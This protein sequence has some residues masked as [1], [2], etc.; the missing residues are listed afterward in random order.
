MALI[1]IRIKGRLAIACKWQTSRA[2]SL[3]V[4]CSGL[5][6]DVYSQCVNMKFLHLKICTIVNP[7]MCSILDQRLTPEFFFALSRS[8]FKNF[9]YGFH[10][11]EHTFRIFRT[12]VLYHNPDGGRV[13]K[14]TL[15]FL[16]DSVH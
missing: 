7:R 8:L 16:S 9:I 10:N 12:S 13:T 1:S 2:S 3:I 11:R 6:N 4:I 15:M 5:S 14:N